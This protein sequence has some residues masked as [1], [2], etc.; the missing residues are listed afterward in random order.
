MLR[1]NDAAEIFEHRKATLMGQ[2][3]SADVMAVRREDSK[4]DGF[5]AKQCL[6]RPDDGSLGTLGVAM[7]DIELRNSVLAQE[8][9]D[10]DLR[11]PD[12]P[13]GFGSEGHGCNRLRGD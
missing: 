5:A 7:E 8:A 13:G 3:I 6:A 10:G 9:G 4:P 12:I 1:E 11:N 2:W